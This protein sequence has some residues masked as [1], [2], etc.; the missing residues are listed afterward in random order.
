[1]ANGD[2]ITPFFTIWTEPRAT[3][4][5]IVD[6]NPTRYVVALA[7]TGPAISTLESQ[8]SKAIGNSANL[9]PLWPVWVPI[10]VMLAAAVGIVSLYIGGAVWRWAGGLLGG[11]ASSVDVRAAIAWS[12]VPGIAGEIVLLFAILMGTPVPQATPGAMPHIDPGFYKF[13]A[14]EA[15]LGIWGFVILL[16]TIGEVHR[17]SAWRALV[18]GLIPPLIA[19][20]SIG[21]LIF[22][23][24]SLVGHH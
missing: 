16:K 19:F 15:V 8:W 18:A 20:A 9:S 22:L 14:V 4:R 13:I 21:L 5:R 12:S 7:A 11:V 2:S 23:I 3:I 17:F 10:Y 6:T 1:M 24:W